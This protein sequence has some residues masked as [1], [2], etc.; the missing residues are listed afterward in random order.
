MV[1]GNMVF[2]DSD[3]VPKTIDTEL[4]RNMV[5]CGKDIVPKTIDTGLE[6]NIVLSSKFR[7]LYREL[8][9][10]VEERKYRTSQQPYKVVGW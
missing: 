8:E 1:V 4:V 6:G 10:Q 7:Y 5:S 3:T 2:G 9:V